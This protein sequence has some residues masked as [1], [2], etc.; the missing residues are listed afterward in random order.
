VQS[1]AL[2]N[3]DGSVSLFI[4]PRRVPPGLAEHVGPG[5]SWKPESEAEAV[6]KQYRDK[7]VLVDGAASNAWIGLALER[8]GATLAEAED[9]VL[10]PKACKNPVEVA[11]ARRAHVRDGVAEVRF[12]AWL[13]GQIAAGEL[14]DEAALADQLYSFRS[15]GEQLQG[16]SFDTISAAGPNAAMCHYNHRNGKPARL[17]MNSAYLFDS[18]AQYND[19]TTDITRT[20]AIGDPGQDV[21]RMFTLVLKGHIALAL[22]RFPAGTSGTQLDVLARQFLWQEGFDYDH[23]TGHGVGSFLSVHEGPQR[24]AK[25]GN[26]VA[27]QPGMIISNEPGY[28]RDGCFG[29]RCENLV[30]VQ[31]AEN[32][33]GETPVMEFETITLAPFD[34]RLMLPEMLNSAELDWLNSYHRRVWETLETQ[35]GEADRDWLYRAT[36]T[37]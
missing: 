4:D 21:R 29:I 11:G 17:E 5:V 2:L 18:G 19:G 22:A 37:I 1:F 31:A 24:I 35:L 36:A 10:M 27:L 34:R 6:F 13:D 15:D 8:A 32:C 30:V 23:G 3:S 16:S 12:L 25:R 9:P 26:G 28:Y 20:V 33:A 7:T 14:P